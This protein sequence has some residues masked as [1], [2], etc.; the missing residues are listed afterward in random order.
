MS[1]LMPPAILVLTCSSLKKLKAKNDPNLAYHF[2]YGYNKEKGKEQGY[3]QVK[4][5]KIPRSDFKALKTHV[6]TSYR[7]TIIIGTVHYNENKETF[8]FRS[9]KA[10]KAKKTWPKSKK[11][12]SLKAVRSKVKGFAKSYL[13]TG[14]EK[15]EALNDYNETFFDRLNDLFLQCFG[16]GDM[17]VEEASSMH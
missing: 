5:T 7:S 6:A 17:G 12:K 9:K 14:S 4:K 13:S 8:E 11:S 3:L 16:F 1:D 2:L 15:E 10:G